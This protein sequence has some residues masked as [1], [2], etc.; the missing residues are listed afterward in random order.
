MQTI[1]KPEQAETWQQRQ[2]QAQRNHKEER[3]G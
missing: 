1:E 2:T 3:K